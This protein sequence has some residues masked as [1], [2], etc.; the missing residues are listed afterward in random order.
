MIAT[1]GPGRRPCRFDVVE[2]AA[3]DEWPHA[4]Y[5][6]HLLLCL[7]GHGVDPHVLGELA[8]RLIGGG[9]GAALFHGPACER[10]REA[11]EVE[12]DGA[13]D[14]AGHEDDRFAD[15]LF[16]WAMFR[17]HDTFPVPDVR[18]AVLVDQPDRSR[19]IHRWLPAFC[20]RR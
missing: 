12:A 6:A 20:A 14:L 1:Y 17:P 3:L 8:R 16:S 19:D 4:L 15:T 13:I 11:F 10:V 2:I 7:D 18:T 9:L 5:P